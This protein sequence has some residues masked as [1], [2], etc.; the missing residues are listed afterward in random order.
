MTTGLLFDCDEQVAALGFGIYCGR[1]M[2]FDKAVGLMRGQELVGAV[3]FQHY[4]GF[5]LE[6][7][8]Y[9]K[10]TL[11]PGVVKCLARYVIAQFD[12]ARVTV[13]VNKRRKQRIRALVRFGF[14][15]EGIQRC[16]YGKQ[17]STSNTAVR[18]VMFR[19]R[20]E[21]LADFAVSKA[22]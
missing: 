2:R 9:G 6:G 19:D 4:N 3:I 16:Y 1:A 7:S 22:A 18:L 21:Q 10:G 5:N 12:A 8:Y 11:T 20:L 17:D 14:R 15:F 13:V